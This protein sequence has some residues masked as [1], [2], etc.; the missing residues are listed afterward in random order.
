MVDNF[1]TQWK[2]INLSVLKASIS[3]SRRR[4]VPYPL[5]GRLAQLYDNNNHVL[6]VLYRC[7]ISNK[8]KYL[9]QRINIIIWTN[10][11][12]TGG[13][14]D[15]VS[16]NIARLGGTCP[17]VYKSLIAMIMVGNQFSSRCKCSKHS[18]N[19]WNDSNARIL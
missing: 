8:S 7:S 1:L 5:T 19:V 6:K 15:T 10:N 3:L 12:A 18:Q 17:K 9:D 2:Q 16:W 13:K 4:K 11:T 14:Q